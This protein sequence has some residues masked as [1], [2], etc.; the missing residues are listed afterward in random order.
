MGHALPSRHT[1]EQ[2]L[3]QDQ[4]LSDR[5]RSR[6]D[7]VVN[8]NRIAKSHNLELLGTEHLPAH[9]EQWAKCCSYTHSQ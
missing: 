7:R 3:Q 9:D 2:A 5:P 1:L 8:T 4:S 6:P